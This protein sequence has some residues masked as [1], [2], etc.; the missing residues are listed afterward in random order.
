MS[1]ELTSIPEEQAIYD[2]NELEHNTPV[3]RD[4]IELCDETLRDGIQSPSV[5][6]P[7]I[8]TKLELIDLMDKLGITIAN[9]GLPGAGPRAVEDVTTIAK[10]IRDNKLSLKANTAART[11]VRDIEPVVSIQQ[12]VGIPIAA[13]CFLGTSPLRLYAEGWDV[14]FLLRQSE[15]ALKFGIDEGLEVAFVTEDT[16]RSSPKALNPCSQCHQP[17]CAPLGAV[18]HRGYAT[19]DSIKNLVDWT[20]EIIKDSGEDVNRLARSQRPG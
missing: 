6:D 19:P 14:D 12:E 5:V 4:N 8:E 3:F 13:Y 16:I 18:R 2:W 15:K 17:R 9:I 10:Y 7:P 20:R 11:V 1:T